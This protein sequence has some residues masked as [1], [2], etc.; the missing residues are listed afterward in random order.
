MTGP[1]PP[2]EKEDPSEVE[3]REEEEK[4]KLIIPRKSKVTIIHK[5]DTDDKKDKESP[6]VSK[7]DKERKRN[8]ELSP[9]LKEKWTNEISDVQKKLREVEKLCNSMKTQIQQQ[10]K[11]VTSLKATQEHNSKFGLDALRKKID[12]MREI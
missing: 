6:P 10:G 12:R 11:V 1:P 4:K 7:K 9:W 8:G 3:E 2:L 5:K